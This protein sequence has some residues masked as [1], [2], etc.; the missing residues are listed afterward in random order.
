MTSPE[1]YT[2]LRGLLRTKTHIQR[3]A[4]ARLPTAQAEQLRSP[5]DL[6]RLALKPLERCPAALLQFWMEHPRGHLVIGPQRHGY[7][8]GMQTVGRAQ[9]DGVAWVAARR[10]LAEPGLAAP[11][12]ELLDHLLG[13]DGEPAGPWLSDGGGHSPAWQ[14]V[15]RRLLRQFKLG[16][17]P[18]ETAADPHVYFA[19]GLRSYLADPQALNT[20]DPGLE[21]LLRA[22]VCSIDF[23]ARTR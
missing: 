4:V 21:R 12:A 15:G 23:W 7:Q 5:L 19:W 9:L 14:E 1:A 16:Y 22:T 8:P 11:I 13:S 10:L 6:G 17:G 20:V 3:G 18:E 2:A